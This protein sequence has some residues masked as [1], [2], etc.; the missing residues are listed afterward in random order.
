M[1][2]HISGLDTSIIVDKNAG[3]ILA[4]LLYG[5]FR[6][7]ESSVG[8]AEMTGLHPSAC[9]QLLRRIGK[10][11]ASLGFGE[12]VKVRY[13]QTTQKNG[14]EQ[15]ARRALRAQQRDARRAQRAQGLLEESDRRVLQEERRAA[16]EAKMQ[17]EQDARAT[18]KA[19]ATP[20]TPK[21]RR[22]P[23]TGEPT[24]TRWR[25]LGLCGECGRARETERRTCNRCRERSRVYNIPRLLAQKAARALN[26]VPKEVWRKN[27]SASQRATHAR[28]RALRQHPV[29]TTEQ[30]LLT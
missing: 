24:R 14:A 9:R 16:Q 27:L 4:S 10:T 29:P 13:R 3:T 21:K 28:K 8:T 12:P 1:E 7:G 2:Q 22:S 25:R 20:A 11:A 23:S 26:A 19:T 17:A 18:A 15:A 6:R 5:Y 30:S